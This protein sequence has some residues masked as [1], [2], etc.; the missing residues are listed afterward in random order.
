MPF[1][2]IASES[3]DFE[4]S[5]KMNLSKKKASSTQFAGIKRTFK[6]QG[7]SKVDDLIA[8]QSFKNGQ[9]KD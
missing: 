5:A 9:A 7:K 8:K 3:Q 6:Q 2:A 4:E 1:G